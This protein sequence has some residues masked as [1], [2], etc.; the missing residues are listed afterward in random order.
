MRI[1]QIVFT[2]GLVV[3]ALLLLSPRHH[4]Y[5][6]NTNTEARIQGV[7]QEVEEFYCPVTGEIGTH[8]EV[9]T[10]K[11]TVQVHVAPSR[12]L[13]GKQ[14]KFTKGDRVEII[15]APISIQGRQGLVARIVTDGPEVVAVRQ[16]SGKPLW[17]E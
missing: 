4:P 16:E 1:P 13:H 5:A 12:F 14:W 6:Y 11:G 8:L 10:E 3:L 15:G 17:V 7:V 2:T 9:A